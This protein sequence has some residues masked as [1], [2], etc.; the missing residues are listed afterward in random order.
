MGLEL[1]LLEAL[2]TALTEEFIFPTATAARPPPRAAV[3]YLLQLSVLVLLLVLVPCTCTRCLLLFNDAGVRATSRDTSQNQW[4]LYCRR[5]CSVYVLS[6]AQPA[7]SH[8]LF[9]AVAFSR[10]RGGC[11]FSLTQECTTHGHT[12]PRLTRVQ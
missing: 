2:R 3:L 4:I 10:R 9:A 5:V 7:G 1:S 6:V 11:L 12:I 8:L